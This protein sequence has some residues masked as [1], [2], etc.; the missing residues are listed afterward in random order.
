MNNELKALMSNKKISPYFALS[1]FNLKHTKK[2]FAIGALICMSVPAMAALADNPYRSEAKALIASSSQSQSY[3]SSEVTE[4]KEQLFDKTREL[5][6]YKAGLFRASHPQDQAKIIALTQRI[7]DHEKNKVELTAKIQEF[8]KE[9]ANTKKQMNSLEVSTE[10]LT[11]FVQSQRNVA[12]KD[13]QELVNKILTFEEDTRLENEQK[14]NQKLMSDLAILKGTITAYETRI[15]VLEQS[16]EENLQDALQDAAMLKF[17]LADA[18]QLAAQKEHELMVSTL[19]DVTMSLDH[20]K[21]V[22]TKQLTHKEKLIQSKQNALALKSKIDD[23][24]LENIRLQREIDHFT[25]QDQNRQT[26]L[27]QHVAE[28]HVITNQLLEKEEALA[29]TILY[30]QGIVADQ[31]KQ[32]QEL[33]ERLGKEETT[34]QELQH[35]KEYALSQH[36]VEK[37]ILE[38]TMADHKEAMA[39]DLLTY[40]LAI[41]NSMSELQ[42]LQEKLSVE[43][44]LRLKLQHEKELLA[45]E[46]DLHKL[47]TDPSISEKEAALKSALADCESLTTKFL[48]QI[49]F[50]NEKLEH[51][52]EAVKELRRAQEVMSANQAKE[53]QSL[54][55]ALKD[56]E[57]ALI[58][59]LASSK[60][61]IAENQKSLDE[62]Q[63]KLTNEETTNHLLQEAYQDLTSKYSQ[64]EFK[65]SQY[66]VEKHA[67]EQSLLEKEEA[68]NSALMSMD[69]STKEYKALKSALA[70]SESSTTKFLEQIDF[71]QEK[72]AQKE[73]ALKQL[74]NAQ[75]AL[76][77]N[78]SELKQSLEQTLREKEEILEESLAASQNAIAEN[79]QHID[80]LK[81]KLANEASINQELQ[82]AHHDLLS[83]YSH[84]EHKLSQYEVEKLA[85][86]QSLLEKEDSLRSALTASQDS[87]KEYSTLIED[88]KRKLNGIEDAHHELKEVH[89]ELSSSHSGMEQQLSQQQS[90]KLLLEHSLQEKEE[91]LSSALM[92]IESSTNEYKTLIEALKEKLTHQETV[93]HQLKQSNES[94]TANLNE[95]SSAQRLQQ[96][97]ASLKEISELQQQVKEDIATIDYL[98]QETAKLT[99]SFNEKLAKE[100]E[101]EK[102]LHS[103]TKV[104]EH[105]DHALAEANSAFSMVHEYNSHLEIENADLK[106]RLN[107]LETAERTMRKETPS[108]EKETQNIISPA[109][110]QLFRPHTN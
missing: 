32:A 59:C 93:N 46:F 83:R 98:K 72:L 100:N 15:S 41:N 57:E 42:A 97:F 82:E 69:S 110:L 67:L 66:E 94:F 86:E 51:E 80:I 20:A 104:A 74:Q 19:N 5:N 48:E 4:L 40:Q 76:Y 14:L 26:V 35:K 75:E 38:K 53:K 95:Q 105:Q 81:E 10:A 8:E 68:L 106:K 27:G 92:S 23:I 64:I 91:A 77:V 33:Q 21:T 6:E 60:N 45:A 103:L 79:Q 25:E 16:Y 22:K 109:L 2:A 12:E 101:L 34:R 102:S 58:L 9:L 31:T 44:T 99:A 73:E 43:E 62:L 49:D 7:A 1:G 17:N 55:K 52:E 61:A 70:D 47:V 90:E 87:L 56:K 3:Q 89:H 84:T 54:E 30:Y 63:E 108:D 37:H 18:R 107:T 11:D 88:L 50:L 96:E 78:H 85:L 29:S 28:R 71:I 39:H 65:L 24:T 36:E 13:K